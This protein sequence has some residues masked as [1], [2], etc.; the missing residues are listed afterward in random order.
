MGR[1]LGRPAAAPMAVAAAAFLASIGCAQL[2]GLLGSGAITPPKVSFHGAQLV[3]APSRRDLSA[4]FCPKVVREK[5]GLGVGADILCAGFFGRVPSQQSMG[6]GFDLNFGVENP[7][8]VP[9]PLS[10]ILTAI[11]LFPQAS[12]QNLGAVCFR[13]CGPEDAACRAGQDAAACRN[14]KGDIRTLDDFPAALANM[15]I[16][17][18]ISAASGQTPAFHAPKVLAGSALSVV[19]RF[20]VAPEA[21]LPIVQQLATQAAAELRSGKELTFGIPYKLEGTVF[22]DAGSLGRVAAGFGPVPGEWTLPAERLLP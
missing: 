3:S 10:E 15:L 16:T 8:R 6:I 5:V 2:E 9:L 21:L 22:A 19:A 14:A 4:F 1:S 17:Q 12:A 13:L 11:T 20:T 7:N 18:G